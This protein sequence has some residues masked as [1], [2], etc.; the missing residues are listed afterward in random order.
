MGDENL[1]AW[2]EKSADALPGIRDHT[3]TSA[4]R[5]ED[6]GRRR[7]TGAGHAVPVDVEHCQRAGVHRIVIARVHMSD[8]AYVGRKAPVVPAAPAQQ[9]TSCWQLGRR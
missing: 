3:G 1:V 7:K 8:V 9:K 4:R 6:A 2:F 5:L